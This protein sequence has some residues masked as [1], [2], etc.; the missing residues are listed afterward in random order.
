M[1]NSSET[2]YCSWT[3]KEKANV[4]GKVKWKY[5]KHHPPVNIVKNKKTKKQDC[6]LE[7]DVNSV[8]FKHLNK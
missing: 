5:S 2:S 4:E 3:Y 6:I 7:R 8:T 1:N